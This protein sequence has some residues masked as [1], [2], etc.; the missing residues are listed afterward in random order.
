MCFNWLK[1]QLDNIFL[2]DNKIIDS[3]DDIP[4]LVTGRAEPIAGAEPVEPAVESVHRICLCLRILQK[5]N[6]FTIMYSI[7][8]FFF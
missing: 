1:Y 2:I 7:V 5:K 4:E 8:N 6:N 3:V